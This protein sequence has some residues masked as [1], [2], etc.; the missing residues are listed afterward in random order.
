MFPDR[1]LLHTDNLEPQGPSSDLTIDLLAQHRQQKSPAF[2]DQFPGII[3]SSPCGNAS[4]S[5]YTDARYY[6]DRAV[7]KEGSSVSD[8]L[9]ASV[10]QFPGVSQCLT[11]T[12]LAELADG[13]HRVST[14]T[15]V[16]VFGL[17]TRGGT[18]LY[19][20]NQPPAP[21]SVVVQITST[22]S[23]GG[24]YNGQILTGASSA[25]SSGN[26]AMPE[27]LSA[28][29]SALILNEEE[30][31]QSG[32]RLTSCYAIGQIVGTSGGQTVVMIRGA[33]GATSGATSLSGSGTSA[34]GTAWSKASNATPVTVTLQTRTFWD[35]TGGVLYG[36]SRT[37][38]FDA[39]GQLVSVSAESQYT[40]DTPT[41]C[42]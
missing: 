30:D 26:L 27:G 6:V 7:P 32:H 40:I 31:G 19:I 37:L 9:S 14:G 23:G 4:G 12:N 18:K 39:R 5:D 24:K 29:S 10:D 34:D 35:S 38:S 36:F 2:V 15:V 21:V 8:L 16:Q 41:A 13:T 22:A 20:F 11:A 42:S 3:R 33:L 1:D 28:S 25:T 17:Y